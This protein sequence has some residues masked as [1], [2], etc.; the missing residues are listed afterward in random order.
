MITQVNPHQCKTQWQCNLNCLRRSE[1]L[2]ACQA[3]LKNWSI[4]F[5]RSFRRLPSNA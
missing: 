5:F 4:K 3:R 1:N 2:N